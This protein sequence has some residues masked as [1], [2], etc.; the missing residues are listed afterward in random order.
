M[1]EGGDYQIVMM[2][3]DS[4]GNVGVGT[5]YK[6]ILTVST[7]ELE[8]PP[9]D[10]GT[11]NWTN[12]TITDPEYSQII[13]TTTI[14]DG[15][16]K[17]WA[18]SQYD[19]TYPYH[20][21]FENNTVNGQGWYSGNAT[22]SGGNAT[23][24]RG[25]EA[26]MIQI[27]K[28]IRI[29]KYKILPYND[30]NNYNPTEFYLDGSNDGVEWTEIDHQVGVTSWPFVYKEFTIT[31]PH[32]P[33]YNTF[34]L[35]VLTINSGAFVIVTEMK[36]YGYPAELVG[37]TGPVPLSTLRTT[38][39]EA[40]FADDSTKLLALTGE[41]VPDENN[42]TTYKALATTNPNLTNSEVRDLITSNPTATVSGVADGG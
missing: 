12:S 3:K 14:A 38:L 34:R 22:F 30:T 6:E 26:L 21:A 18:T 9:S 13:Y 1:V 10:V 29:T 16:Y 5:F 24:T 11:I 41:V 40:V 15:E 20:K 28:S 37:Y 23:H 36:I 33:V 2:A 7:T 25:F 39:T 4:T 31:S 32:V 42:A 8:Y 17:V 35:R 27:P 19:T